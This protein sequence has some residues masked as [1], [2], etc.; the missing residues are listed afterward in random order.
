[1]ETDEVREIS[2]II[3]NDIGNIIKKR[4]EP[5]SIEGV[6]KVLLLTTVSLCGGTYSTLSN[7]IVEHQRESFKRDFT[8][9]IVSTINI[10]P[11]KLN[12]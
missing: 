2:A 3:M 1:M 6:K 5:L 10:P 7:E 4:C 9:L 12:G 11:E 8:N